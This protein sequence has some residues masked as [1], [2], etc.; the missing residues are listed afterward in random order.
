MGAAGVLL[1][2]H[3]A[4]REFRSTDRILVRFG[5]FGPAG[6]AS[7]AR[8]LDQRGARVSDLAVSSF[9]P[10]NNQTTPVREVELPTTGLASGDYVLELSASAGPADPVTEW[11]AFRLQR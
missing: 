8:L 7:R 10:S 3:T 5:V 4:A 6:V 2:L 1:L 11:L 9:A